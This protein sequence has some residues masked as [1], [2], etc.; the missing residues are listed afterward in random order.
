MNSF[1]ILFSPIRIAG[2]ELKNR[3]VMPA[4]ATNFLVDGTVTERMI[5]YFR[6]RARG[7]AGLL[8]TEAAS[9]RAVPGSPLSRLHLN[10]SDDRFLPQLRALQTPSTGTGA[11]S[12][13]S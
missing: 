1:P 8:V 12:P 13:S 6:A 4:M 9:V 2:M 7:G 11:R 5:D 10:V 3:I